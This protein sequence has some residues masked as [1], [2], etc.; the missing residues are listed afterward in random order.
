MAVAVWLGDPAS[1]KTLPA[2]V[3]ACDVFRTF[4]SAVLDGQPTEQFPQA[5]DPTYKNF[6]DPTYH[7]G[8]SASSSNTDDEKDDEKKKDAEDKDA[9]KGKD[10]P[11]PTPTPIRQNTPAT[12]LMAFG[13]IF[14][15]IHVEKG[16]GPQ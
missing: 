2:R 11:A 7:V 15:I 5:A 16:E 9:D 8:G 13:R 1:V 3:G 10:D 14:E 6:S 12:R 4:M